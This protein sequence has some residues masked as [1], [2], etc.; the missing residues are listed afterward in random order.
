MYLRHLLRRHHHLF[1]TLPRL[2]TTA[3]TTTKFL[4]HTLPKPF[5][6]T[7]AAA[8]SS[9]ASS[10]VNDSS[11]AAE[12]NEFLSR[13]VHSMRSKLTDSF[14]TC[15]KP[16]IDS[17]LVLVVDK[18]VAE[19]DRHGGAVEG[20]A[21]SDDFG[22]EELTKTMREVSNTV[23]HEMEVEKT[24]EKMKK[25]LQSEEVKSMA[26]FASEI[27]VRGDL[28]R[29]LRFKW[30]K[31]AMEDAEFYSELND[32]K[33]ENKDDAGK[34]VVA[35]GTEGGGANALPK[36]HGRINY[37]LYGLDL[38]GE[39]WRQV[40]EKV[41][42]AE[43]LVW[44]ADA[45]AITGK[46]KLITEQIVGLGLDEVE[47]EARVSE[48]VQEWV[49]LLQPS[50]VDW[51]ALLDNVKSRDY[52]VYLK[53]A[54]RVLVEP[55]FQ[56]DIRDY[57]L[58]IHAHAK[59]RHTEDVERLLKKMS[60]KGL[61]PDVLTLTAL[62]HLY[63]KT[64]NLGQ[65]KE[66]FEA[67]R[68]Q[69]FKPDMEI[70]NSM[71]TAY[72]NAGQPKAAEKLVNEMELREKPSQ[73]IYMSLLQA[74]A[75][76]GDT[77][78]AQ[79]IASTMEVG[80]FQ[81][82]AE[83]YSLLIQACAKSGKPTEARNYFENMMSRG[84]KP[85][86]KN[87]SMLISTYEKKN[88]LDNALSLLLQLEKDGFEPGIS[89]YCVLVDWLGKLQLIDEAEQILGK[90]AQLGEAPPLKLQVSL[91]DMYARAGTEKKALQALGVLEAKNA[92]LEHEDFER[93]ILGL[94]NGGFV[95]DANRI[96]KLMETRGFT[97]S[98]SL[99]VRNMATN[100]FRL[101][102]ANSGPRAK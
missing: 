99:E 84:Y 28:L 54:E 14:P 69:G 55:S 2:T 71:I 40:A 22:N 36:R 9:A 101:G 46:C 42:E 48:L 67:L 88:E 19:M 64:N 16:T 77:I 25:Y 59:E 90:I 5:H 23:F 8:T 37:K 96:Q 41:H 31:E 51:V 93:I 17:M 4:S 43:E 50:K 27:G 38:S 7:T 18:L 30:A 34:G 35:I 58:L 63:S 65:A 61:G 98:A 33:D 80:R 57:S 13:F 45:K 49:E 60:E 73:D 21:A 83:F 70:Y 100:A 94:L 78:G 15:D 75:Q 32:L 20:A 10:A 1:S 53:M 6:S 102:S 74:F 76:Q 56:S 26:R 87:T 29:E 44:P 85:D 39:K 11:D 92:L 91:L 97:P 81:P 3:A 62:L 95:N 52:S 12:T 86:D 89:T 72:V 66:A 79:R 47:D 24:K 68:R 82:T